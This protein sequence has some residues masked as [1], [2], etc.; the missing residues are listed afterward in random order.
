MSASTE[1]T[2]LS[3]SMD[4]F[5]RITAQFKHE[6]AFPQTYGAE[7]VK[8]LNRALDAELTDLDDQEMDIEWLAIQACPPKAL[9]QCGLIGR[10]LRRNSMQK[11]GCLHRESM[12]RKDGSDISSSGGLHK[13]MPGVA[14]ESEEVRS[15][16][17]D[18]DSDSVEA[19]GS[20]SPDD[21]EN[22]GPAN[23]NRRVSFH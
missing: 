16:V 14:E 10:I 11:D 19:A 7:F 17:K 3:L 9:R 8:H 13:V 21:I 15:S 20:D 2:L 12:V 6:L 23:A 4:R 22:V 1:S 18:S 5:Q